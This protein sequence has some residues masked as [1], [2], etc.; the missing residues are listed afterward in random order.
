MSMVN[1][2]STDSIVEFD[3]PSDI[4]NNKIVVTKKIELAVLTKL[5]NSLKDLE[6][7]DLEYA[8]KFHNDDDEVEIVSEMRR[9]RPYWEYQERT[10]DASSTPVT[11]RSSSSRYRTP[12]TTAFRVE[13]SGRSYTAV[14]PDGILTRGIKWPRSK[15]CKLAAAISCSDR[16]T[17]PS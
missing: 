13:P 17:K 8:L 3:E 6:P 2:S 1:V 7:K 14:T 16:S 10:D 4:N 9:A 12:C 5:S 11:R 15:Y